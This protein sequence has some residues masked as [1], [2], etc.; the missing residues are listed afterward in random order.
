MNSAQ[1]KIKAWR[2]SPAKFVWDNFQVDPDPWQLKVLDAFA[3]PDPHKSRISMQA[4]A[5]PGK[6]AVLAWCGWNFLLCYGSRGNH[7]KGAAVSVTA[8]NLKDNLWAEL[9]KWQDRSEVLKSAFQW[10]KERIFAKD[11]PAT[12]FLSARSF[13]KTANA[14]EQGRTLSG[15][16]SE[17]VLALIDES[18]D[19]PLAVAKAAEQALST[20]PSFGKILQAGNPTSLDGILYAAATQLSHLWYIIRITGDP[21]DPERSSRIDATWA[22]EQIKTYGRDN[23]WVMAYILGLFP[24][25][26]INTLLGPDE[27]AASMRRNPSSDTYTHTQKRLGVDVARFGDDRTIIFPR[28]GLMAFKPIEM[29]NARTPDIAARV[30]NLKASWGSEMEMVDDTGGYGAGVIDSMLQAGHSP[31]AV[32]F[33]GKAMDPRYLNKRAEMW[34]L[35]AEW[36]KRGGALPN[37]PDLAKELVTP[38]YTFQGGKFKLEEKAQIKERLGFSPDKADA[39][40]LTF[41]LPDMPGAHPI[42]GQKKGK[43]L[44]DYDPFSPERL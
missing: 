30:A 20:R 12:W 31:Y 29:R 36:V 41:A 2:E 42:L 34:F 27:V 13:S 43:M 28:Q 14:D 1:R 44:A 15:L 39:L 40:A 33:A 24:P 10:T 22:A 3:D 18:G 23:P 5:G 32:N 7:P 8:D 6:S 26:S 37:D 4:C 11:H 17:Y 16:H 35:L 21:D 9:S 19:I 25:S 38:T